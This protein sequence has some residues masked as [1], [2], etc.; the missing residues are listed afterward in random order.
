MPDS[1][2]AMGRDSIVEGITDVAF[3]GLSYA[4]G[5]LAHVELSWLSPGKLRRTVIVGTKKMV[6]YDDTSSEPIRI[7][8]HGVKYEDPETFGQYQLSYRTGDI[9]SPKLAT[10]EP[11]VTELE[12]F[13]GCVRSGDRAGGQ[14]ELALDVV[15]LLEAAERSLNEKGRHVPLEEV[16]DARTIAAAGER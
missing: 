2:S 3:I 5:L 10:T 9:V 13:I 8:D 16:T 4:S 11:I 6:V 14:T 7:F 12:D 15:N 1:V